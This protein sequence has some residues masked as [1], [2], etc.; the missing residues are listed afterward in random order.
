MPPC[1]SG[2]RHKWPLS[3]EF[4][5]TKN[6]GKIPRLFEYAFYFQIGYAIFGEALGLAIPLLG[7]GILAS[8]A[9]LCVMRLGWQAEGVFMPIA[10]ALPP[11]SDVADTPCRRLSLKHQRRFIG[12]TTYTDLA[13]ARTEVE[14]GITFELVHSV[15]AG[16]VAVRGAKK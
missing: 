14:H 4:Y 15:G 8:L 13:R 11:A 16:Q 10:S 9:A 5:G 12:Q 7:F 3:A 2:L 6:F 1:P